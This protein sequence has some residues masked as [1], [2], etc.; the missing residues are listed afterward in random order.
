MSDTNVNE[1]AGQPPARRAR[2]LLVAFGCSPYLGSEPGL[3]WHRVLEIAKRHDAC[4]ICEESPEFVAN[5]DR[6]LAEN[7]PIP[8]LRFHYVPLTPLVRRLMRAPGLYFVGYRGWQRRAYAEALRLHQ[9]RPFDL[10]HQVNLGTY[11]EPGYPWRLGIPIIWGPVGGTQNLPWRF[12]LHNG[13]AAAI[14]EALRSFANVVQF[15]YTPHV[16]RGIREATVIVASSGTSLRDFRRVHGIEPVYLCDCGT[17]SV[18]STPKIDDG[19]DRP[20]RVL[21]VGRL[22]SRKALDLLLMALARL[23]ESVPCELRVVGGGKM[24]HR[25]K[26]LAARLGVEHCCNWLGG[27][28]YEETLK[29]YDWAD[30]FA[31]PSLRDT[32]AAVLPEALSRGV[33]MIAL[34]HQG[35]ADIL[36]EDCG[37]KIPVTTVS[38]AAQGIADA[39]AKLAGDRSEVARMSRGALARAQELLWA[40]NGEQMEAIY[41]RVLGQP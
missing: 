24:K 13:L 27:T 26:K 37:I 1:T 22:Q 7:G 14:P 3:G 32:V 28:S 4:V 34:D 29:N 2:V 11:R 31:F 41:R 25:W 18:S 33:P 16:R 30:V 10:V 21:S 23:P 36:T 17:E 19:A 39:L 8:G 9:E 15:R 5:I 6:Y 12:L 35:V 40:R 38:E 20:L